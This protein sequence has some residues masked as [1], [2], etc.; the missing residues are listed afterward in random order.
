[1]DYLEENTGM[2]MRSLWSIKFIKALVPAAI[3]CCALIFWGATG[4][5]MVEANQQGAVYR[6]GH[7]REETLDAGLHFTLPWPFD[8]VEIY[9]TETVNKITVG[10]DS[11]TTADNLWTEGHN[12]E[13]YKLLLGSGNEVVAINL[14]I[15][16]KIAD[17]RQYLASSASPAS[18]LSAKAYELITERTINT[19]LNTI[20]STDRQ[21]FS[22]SFH[23]ELTAEMAA[24]GTGLSVVGVVLESIHPPV[25]VADI[26]QQMISAEIQAQEIAR[27]L[28]E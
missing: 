10:Y 5:V 18:I 9:D 7:L 21:A 1:M 6:L 26:Y 14:R 24:C 20:L 28:E 16:Y 3:I 27:E 23:E 17:L 11:V 2:T 25:D 8:K 13:E 15:E 22:A 12:S 4:I 19:D